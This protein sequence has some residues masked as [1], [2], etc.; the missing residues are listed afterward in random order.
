M[1]NNCTVHPPTLSIFSPPSLPFLSLSPS[2]FS[3]QKQL[4]LIQ[5]A[6]VPE[7]TDPPPLF[8]PLGEGADE[9]SASMAADDP[10]A[11][12]KPKKGKVSNYI[13]M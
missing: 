4:Q 12:S 7:R 2:L 13:I 3:S 11:S 1:Y 8:D 10:Y 6:M 5:Q 9:L